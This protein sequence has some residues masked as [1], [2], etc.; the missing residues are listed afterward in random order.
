MERFLL[1]GL[2]GC[3]LSSRSRRRRL[4]LWSSRGGEFVGRSDI[5][6]IAVALLQT[7][8]TRGHEQHIQGFGDGEGGTTIVIAINSQLKR[9]CLQEILVEDDPLL[10][11]HRESH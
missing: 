6:E 1:G 2:K 4:F 10:Y 8:E 3:L 7:I 5:V 9:G 11:D